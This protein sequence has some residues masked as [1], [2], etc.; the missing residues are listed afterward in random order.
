MACACLG[1]SADDR[2]GPEIDLGGQYRIMANSANVGWHPATVGSDEESRSFVNQ[3]FRTWLDVKTGDAIG[4]HLQIEIGHVMW[5]EDD[6][7]TKTYGGDE[8]G[9]ELRRGYVTY[10][11]EDVGLLKVGI[12]DW[13]DS[14][15]DLLASGDWDFNVGGVSFTRSL[16]CG[17]DAR[18]RLGGFA[19][20]DTDASQADETMLWTLD[21]SGRCPLTDVLLGCSVYYV[22]DKGGYSYGTFGGPQSTNGV[23]SSHDLWIGLTA[24]KALGATDLNLFGIYNTGSTDDPDWDHRGYATGI[25]C[26]RKVGN[27]RM[28]IQALYAT[29]DDSPADDTSDEFRTVAQS[30]RDNFG[31]AGYWSHLGLTS[32]HGPSDVQDLGV[33]LQNRGLGLMTVQ[34]NYGFQ[35]RDDW[36][37]YLAAGWL[38]S[39]ESNPMNGSREMGVELLTQV[40]LDLGGGLAW[41]GGMAYLA[42]GDFYAESDTESPEDL[43]EVFSRLQLDF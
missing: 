23:L 41:E 24:D 43:Y 8:V 34:A 29:G 38:S 26:A 3:R 42:T 25:R 12:Q 9:V 32:P 18:I 35:I 5:G 7:R 22:D 27:G 15:G 33:S 14:F 21:V 2:A 19:L 4:G 40:R 10:A 1:A 39:T 13:S 31:A 36:S 11:T 20:R 16:P 17:D 30:E 28:G 37:A 6:E